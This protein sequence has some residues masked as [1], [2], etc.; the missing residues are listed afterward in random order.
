MPKIYVKNTTLGNE[1]SIILEGREGLI[2]PLQFKNWNR[3]KV[4]MYYSIVPNSGDDN[5]SCVGGATETL[6]I[7]DIRD[8]FM[9]GLK[10]SQSIAMPGEDGEYFWGNIG[11]TTSNEVA[12]VNSRLNS[13]GPG[14]IYPGSSRQM[15]GVVQS[16]VPNASVTSSFGA[17][18]GV[19]FNFSTTTTANEIYNPGDIPLEI[20][21]RVNATSITNVSKEALRS[22]TLANNFSA[23]AEKMKVDGT[24]RPQALFLYWPFFN[25]RIRVHSIGAF[26]VS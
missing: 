18:M 23:V 9:L 17:Y 11:G 22:E 2:Y 19:E 5:Q 6:Q 14:S 25:Y 26:Q 13:I 4:A 7:H 21:F 10:S 1:K 3:I 16:I 8:R 24:S 20:L 15:Q 12:P